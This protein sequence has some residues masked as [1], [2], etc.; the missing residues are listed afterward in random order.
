MRIFDC[1][2]DPWFLEDD[3]MRE[4]DDDFPSFIMWDGDEA[5]FADEDEAWDILDTFYEDVDVSGRG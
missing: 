2:D 4:D 3:V 1:A 5:R